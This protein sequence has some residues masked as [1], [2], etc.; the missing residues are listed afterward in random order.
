MR[1]TSTDPSVTSKRC[2]NAGVSNR[3]DVSAYTDATCNA[4]SG[5]REQRDNITLS[6]LTLRTQQGPPPPVARSGSGGFNPK[7]SGHDL[8]RE[9]ALRNARQS[10][11]S[12]RHDKVPVGPCKSDPTGLQSAQTA[13]RRS[14]TPPHCTKAASRHCILIRESVHSMH[15]RRSGPSWPLL[16]LLLVFSIWAR[17]ISNMRGVRIY[18]SA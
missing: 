12:A 3:L 15:V 14:T 17:A 18:G 9:A 8:R 10:K 13:V 5:G 6:L 1:S 4:F 16:S 7:Y 2:M 11:D